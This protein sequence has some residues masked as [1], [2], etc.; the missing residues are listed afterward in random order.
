[1]KTQDRLTRVFSDL[2]QAIGDM[3]VLSGRIATNQQE[4]EVLKALG[5]RNYTEFRIPKT[6][7]AQVVNGVRLTLKKTDPG[8]RKFTLEVATDDQKVQKRDKNIN[9]PVQF[10]VG[11]KRQPYELVVNSVNKNEIVGYMATPK[12]DVDRD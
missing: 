9:E 5:D 12:L 4:L 8:A 7:D 11:K 3:G 10:Y 1:V 6:K 2:R